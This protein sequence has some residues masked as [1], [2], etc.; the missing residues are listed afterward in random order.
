MI[1]PIKQPA[2]L[3]SLSANA[4]RQG[5]EDFECVGMLAH[6]DF[7]EGGAWVKFS[8]QMKS[9]LTITSSLF[10][11]WYNLYSWFSVKYWSVANV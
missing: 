1:L 8:Q 3:L 2:L 11:F 5:S 6:V 10:H 7:A 9:L 4:S